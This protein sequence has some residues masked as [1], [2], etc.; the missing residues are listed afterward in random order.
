MKKKLFILTSLLGLLVPAFVGSTIKA[1]RAE[2][3]IVSLENTADKWEVSNGSGFTATNI[4]NGVRIGNLRGTYVGMVYKDKVSLEGLSFTFKNNVGS[5]CKA[6]GFYLSQSKDHSF[7]KNVFF[8]WHDPWAAKQARLEVSTSHDY[9]ETATCYT[10][11]SF[12]KPGFGIAGSMVMDNSDKNPDYVDDGIN[13]SFTKSSPT[14][15]KVTIST[16]NPGALWSSNAN[17]NSTDK[18]C[19]VYLKDSDVQTYLDE[20]GMAYLHVE[21]VDNNA[22]EAY[23]DIT[24]L[25]CNIDEDPIVNKEDLLANVNAIDDAKIQSFFLKPELADSLATLKANALSFLETA[26][27]SAHKS[28][29]APVTAFIK[30]WNNRY[31]SYGYVGSTSVVADNMPFVSSVGSNGA[32]LS[33]EG[34]TQLSMST[35]YG[36]RIYNT[37]VIDATNLVVHFNL[38]VAAVFTS[39]S[40]AVN[41][42]SAPSGY[43]SETDKYYHFELYK[44]EE[45]K[46][47][48]VFGN[49]GCG[50]N[51]S[52]E[53]YEEAVTP[54]SYHGRYI[55]SYSGD[56]AISVKTDYQTN[57]TVIDFNNGASTFT[58][59]DNK[60]IYKNSN[61][62]EKLPANLC[63][64]LFG[65]SGYQNVMINKIFSP[66]NVEKEFTKGSNKDVTLLYDL[67]GA[68]DGVLTIDDV[69]VPNEV[70]KDDKKGTIVVYR[71]YLNT[72]S[73]GVHAVKLSSSKGEVVWN[74]TINAVEKLDI[75]Y[76]RKGHVYMPIDDACAIKYDIDLFG[77]LPEDLDITLNGETLESTSYIWSDY[78]TVFTLKEELVTSWEVGTYYVQMFVEGVPGSCD[79]LITLY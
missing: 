50:H 55:Q 61:P 24:N 69:I 70:M 47:M 52:I 42:S 49:D 72:L 4:E 19:T 76:T 1:N 31:A 59:N 6:G 7:S 35:G 28:E 43:V 46:Y 60:V 78:N 34:D 56:F 25:K 77:L 58:L 79:L 29:Y 14:A 66:D 48:V 71:K 51:I 9:N 41:P 67:S 39:F 5:K 20:D 75:P 62:T 73:N 37:K 13:I 16:V 15:W 3:S 26:P 64:G 30:A 44:V 54:N 40:I 27:E 22:T 36:N 57:K 38:G 10:D 8:L 2:A 23:Y 11:D 53:G 45:D 21:G 32:Q 12:A 65:A 68:S 17:Y 18:T 33:P 74:L 63:F